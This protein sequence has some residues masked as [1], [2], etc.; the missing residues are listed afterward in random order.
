MN[1]RD[2][3]KHAK[4]TIV[5]LVALTVASLGLLAPGASAATPKCFGHDATIVGTRGDDELIGTRGSDVIAA[6]GGND[7]I[8]AK[9]GRDFICARGGVDIIFAGRGRDKIK[10]GGG[11]FD[12]VFPG[13]GNDFVNGGRGEDFLTYEGRSVPVLANLSRGVIFAQGRDRVVGVEGVGGGEVDDVLVGDDGPNSLIGCGGNDTL[14]GRGGDDFINVGAGDDTA[15]GGDGVDALDFVVAVCGPGLGDDTF[16]TSGVAVDLAAG[17]A[18]GGA[19]VGEDIFRNFEIT[20]ATLGD[21]TILGTDGFNVLVGWEGT[22]VI[23]GG[24]GDD[25]LMPGPDDDTVHGGDGAD[26]V[27]YFLSDPIDVGILGPVSVDLADGT[28][29]G[30][31]TDALTSIEGAFGTLLDD[32][33]LGDA[34]PNLPL[35]GD[36]GN[37]DISGGA[38]DDFLDG[39]AFFFGVPFELP[40]DDTLTGG[41]GEDT[42]LGGQT[43]DECEITEPM[44]ASSAR[45]AAVQS[46]LTLRR[47]VLDHYRS[48]SI[49][50]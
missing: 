41:P 11:P 8:E 48:L 27:D 20:G 22:D 10:A 17:T 43:V 30:L 23:Q 49:F 36:E 35:L 5:A 33:L 15:R 3:T 7:F 24:G 34:G 47:G 9:A 32:S 16:A 14:V 4:Q 44:P 18:V 2:R 25:L 6:K 12:V 1:N 19:D 46:R 39:D 29:T 42:C 38:G 37:D 21:D 31:G 13:P 28:A 26:G 45:V 50:R 40:G